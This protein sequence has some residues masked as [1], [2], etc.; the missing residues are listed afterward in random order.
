MKSSNPV[1][2]RFFGSRIQ[3]AKFWAL[4]GA[5]LLQ[6]CVTYAPDVSMVGRSREEIIAL[7]G[8][9]DPPAASPAEPN[10]LD[11]PRGP[12]GKQTFFVYFDEQGKA[13]HFVQVLTEERFSQIR[14]EMS[15]EE[16][17]RLI[18]VSR[19]TFGLARERGFVWS[20]RYFS[21]FCQWFQIEFTKEGK[22]RSTGYSKPPEC[23]VG[24]VRIPVF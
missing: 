19:S 6:S 15:V 13:T 10:R 1:V 17:V 12:M 16:V 3:W 20:Y 22:V 14:P 5:L 11:F 8:P 24:R 7:M 2:T 4:S 18:G 23:R 21:P 9:P